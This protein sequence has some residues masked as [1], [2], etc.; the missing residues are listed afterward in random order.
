MIND[1]NSLLI[2]AGYTGSA[3]KILS[4]ELILNGNT[5]QIAYN[6]LVGKRV[7]YQ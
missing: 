7:E 3:F 4:N 6:S 1:F 2:L 5:F